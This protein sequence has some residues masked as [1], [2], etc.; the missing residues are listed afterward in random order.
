MK[1]SYKIAT[2]CFERFTFSNINMVKEYIAKI[3]PCYF[4][5]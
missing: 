1:D 3:F 2:F 4:Y 5:I